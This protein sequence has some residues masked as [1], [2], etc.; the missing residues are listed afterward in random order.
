MSESSS[1]RFPIWKTLVISA[2]LIIPP[3]IGLALIS[4]TSGGLYASPDEERPWA[5]A[6]YA[7]TFDPSQTTPLLTLADIDVPDLNIQWE[8]RPGEE[9]RLIVTYP[10]D[11]DNEDNPFELFEADS[12]GAVTLPDGNEL[13]LVGV[14][15]VLPQDGD[16]ESERYP[17]VMPEWRDPYSGETLPKED[18]QEK[19]QVDRNEARLFLR[20]HNAEKAPL[21]WLSPSAYDSVTKARVS[22]SSSYSYTNDHGMFRIGL[23]IW[24]QTSV[25]LAF[26]F[27]FGNP[28]TRDIELNKGNT[29]EFGEDA[30]FELVEI[31]PHGHGSSSWGK[32]S[33]GV[34]TTFTPRQ[35]SENSNYRTFLFHVWPP[36]NHKLAEFV[37]S[38]EKQPRLMSGN[39]GMSDLLFYGKDSKFDNG[40]IRRYP[41]LG[42]AM[43][44]LEKI[45]RLP[46]VEN[47]F[48]APISRTEIRYEHSFLH[49]VS[50]S[51]LSRQ[52]VSSSDY[53]VDESALPLVFTD[54]TPIEI[55]EKF[56][57]LTGEH[58]YFDKEEFRITNEK[59]ETTFDRTWEK[60]REMW[61]NW[62]P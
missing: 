23:D 4:T 1:N 26:D 10:A 8:E 49:T 27:A 7:K 60:I 22:S 12:R 17:R 24:H 62:F 39:Y 56:E 32:G 16:W 59:P 28:E 61:K 54:T 29:T 45:P 53:E 21:R 52:S 18:W 41:R 14:A 51:V 20:V 58:I 6:S 57:E 2:L 55:L 50:D 44:H 30:L 36:N 48:E 33:H 15:V 47:L 37:Y 5:I 38:T 19:V 11:D 42:R 25:D 31:F 13:Q 9:K 40:I 34:R 43:V 35:K 46:E 3:L